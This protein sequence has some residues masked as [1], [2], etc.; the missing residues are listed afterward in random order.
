MFEFLSKLKT[1]RRKLFSKIVSTYFSNQNSDITL[2]DQAKRLL[3]FIEETARQEA[4]L[5]QESRNAD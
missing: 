1:E 5:R 3:V 4:K 2:N